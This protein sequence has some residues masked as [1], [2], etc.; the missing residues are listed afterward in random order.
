M[1]GDVAL[2][3]IFSFFSFCSLRHEI[4]SYGSYTVF[5]ISQSI[6]TRSFSSFKLL[7]FLKYRLWSC[8]RRHVQVRDARFCGTT[9]NVEASTSRTS[10]HF[11]SQQRSSI[12]SRLQNALCIVNHYYQTLKCHAKSSSHRSRR[13]DP[14]SSRHQTNMAAPPR[15]PLR[16]GLHSL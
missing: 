13:S 3:P 1:F 16:P 14:T 6:S 5:V 7:L 4:L 12:V 10:L 9:T 15:L 2:R 8:M 11:H